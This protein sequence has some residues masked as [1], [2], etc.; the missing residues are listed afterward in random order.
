MSEL[1]VASRY[2]K[3]LIDLAVEQNSLEA[4]KA[5]MELFVSTLK[6][7]SELQAVLKNPIIPL[8]KKSGVLDG[9][10]KSKVSKATDSFFRI[11]VNKGRAELLYGTG[12]EF[13]NQY[14]VLKGIITARVVSASP[15][16][17]ENKKE[18][19]EKIKAAT[20]NQ[21]ILKTSVDPDLIG[22]FVLNI[23]DRQIDT[24]LEGSLNRLR[25]DFSQKI[26]GQL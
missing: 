7:H 17:E 20:G 21:V 22:G 10:F 16:S 12:R 24:S 26:A 2:A 14:N 13:L 8:V 25:K 1:T 18:L 19:T 15:L 4:V 3:S 5:D 6:A 23:G 9:L 11:M